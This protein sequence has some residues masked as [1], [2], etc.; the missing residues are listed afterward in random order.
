MDL[1]GFLKSK[2]H[3]K[4]VAAYRWQ[5]EAVNYAKALGFT[6]NK[7]W[8]RFFKDNFPKAEPKFRSIMELATRET[9][10]NKE[11]YFYFMYYNGHRSFEENNARRS[12]K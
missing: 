8:F 5:D 11:K 9:I 3:L 10:K 7:G 1:D 12:S 2:N 6:P 4:K